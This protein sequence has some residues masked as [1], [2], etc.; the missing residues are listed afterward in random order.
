MV[1]SYFD[2]LERYVFEELYFVRRSRVP[3]VLRTPGISRRGD[4]TLNAECSIT[5]VIPWLSW[6]KYLVSGIVL[7]GSELGARFIFYSATRG[8]TGDDRKI[9]VRRHGG[10]LT[11][12]SLIPL[13][14]EFVILRPVLLI[15][16]E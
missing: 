2:L 4:S 11:M 14:T 12:Q 5:T 13:R 15:A 7:G 16:D 1:L 9:G 6:Y 8:I 10:P 3:G